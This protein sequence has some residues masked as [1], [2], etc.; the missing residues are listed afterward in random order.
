VASWE[1]CVEILDNCG[2]PEKVKE[3]CRAVAACAFALAE[4][5][6]RRGFALDSELCRRG[7]LL[8]DVCRTE[9]WHAPRAMIYLL[10]RGLRAEALIAG[11]HMG[12]YIDTDRIAEKEIVYLADKITQGTK[13]VSVEERYA[14]SLEKFTGDEEAV[15]AAIERRDQS[16]A[17]AAYAEKILGQPLHEFDKEPEE[18]S[19]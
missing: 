18:C 13:R 3:H 10:D 2:Q 4:A 7:G 12:A 19:K 1:K 9:R 8:H 11:A 16:L 17:L 5:F 14:R 6:N 15:R